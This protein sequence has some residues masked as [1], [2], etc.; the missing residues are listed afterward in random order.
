MFPTLA[1]CKFEKYGMTGQKRQID[2]LCSLSINIVMDKIF[3][4]IWF[5]YALLAALIFVNLIKYTILVFPFVRMLYMRQLFSK[6][7]KLKTISHS[8]MCFILSVSKSTK[9]TKKNFNILLLF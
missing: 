1:K 5:Y 7:L 2:L 6:K 8:Q 9:F 4:F 3:L